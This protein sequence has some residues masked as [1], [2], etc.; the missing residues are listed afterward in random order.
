MPSE[1]SEVSGVSQSNGLE[2]RREY[3]KTYAK[4]WTV[5]GEY[6]AKNGGAVNIVIPNGTGYLKNLKEL[7]FVAE[8]CLW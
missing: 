5:I 3:F 7:A 4:E 1:L 2:S 8:K 6:A